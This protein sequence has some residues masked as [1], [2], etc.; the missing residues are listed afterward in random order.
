MIIGMAKPCGKIVAIDSETSELRDDK[1]IWDFG[2]VERKPSNVAGEY[3]PDERREIIILDADLSWANPF[4]LDI[5]HAYER[6]PALNGDKRED[7]IEYMS[8][9]AAAREIERITRGAVILGIVPD[10]DVWGLKPFLRRHGLPYSGYYHLVDTETLGAG[11]LMGARAAGKDV[12]A[13]GMPPWKSEEISRLLGVEPP[14]GEQRH[15][16]S[17]DA[18]WVM[19]MWDAIVSSAG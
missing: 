5:G 19:Q 17:G 3:G 14:V 4:S 8:Q 15:T 6:H 10:F 7:G 18:R 11:F 13:I 2:C 16:A 9:A 12:P 1:E